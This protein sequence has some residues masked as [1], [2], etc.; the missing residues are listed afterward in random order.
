MF[1]STSCSVFLAL[2]QTLFQARLEKNLGA[3][4]STELVSKVISAGATDFRSVV[5]QSDVSAVIKAYGKSCTQ[6]FVSYSFAQ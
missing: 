2:G 4:I 3:V 6:V 5:P 1:V